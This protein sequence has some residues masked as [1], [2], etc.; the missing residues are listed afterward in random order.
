VRWATLGGR[1][2]NTRRR[3][4]L[5]QI[6]G[7]PRTRACTAT[8]HRHRGVDVDHALEPDVPFNYTQAALREAFSRSSDTSS[9]DSLN[10]FWKEVSYGRHPPRQVLALSLEPG[11]HV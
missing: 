3:N 6:S 10:G 8:V 11:L 7:F 4:D 1:E 5:A 2:H 9:M